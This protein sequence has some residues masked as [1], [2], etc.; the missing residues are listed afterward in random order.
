M[1]RFTNIKNECRHQSRNFSGQEGGGRF[2]ELDHIDKHFIKNTIKKGPAGRRFGVFSP[3][4]SY[5]YIL[6]G[7]FSP[8]VDT[9]RASLSKVRTLLLIFKK[10]RVGLRS[11][12]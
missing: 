8:K 12:P 1:K 9:F 7:N 11:L 6:I 5:N 2:V 4:Y 10:S 3:R